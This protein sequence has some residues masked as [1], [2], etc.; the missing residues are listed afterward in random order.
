MSLL[1]RYLTVWILLAMLF[2]VALGVL[3]PSVPAALSSMQT[4]STNI[5]LAVGLILMMFPPLAKV[6]YE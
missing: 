4:G 1:D 2:G 5:P 3:V 6:R